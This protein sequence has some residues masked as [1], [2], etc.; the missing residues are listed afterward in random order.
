MRSSDASTPAKPSGT[1]QYAWSTAHARRTAT[2]GIGG[3]GRPLSNFGVVRGCANHWGV[4]SP[5]EEGPRGGGA[6]AAPRCP[7]TGGEALTKSRTLGG[8][9]RDGGVVHHRLDCVSVVTVADHGHHGA[10]LTR[11]PCPLRA[12]APCS[13][14][15]PSW[16][17][18]RTQGGH[19]VVEAVVSVRCAC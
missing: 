15:G 13:A 6:E 9:S 18:R 1:Q 19:C 17:A 2:S 4:Q 12:Q 3:S 16:R 11:P 8:S 7:G 5:A 14:L 10:S